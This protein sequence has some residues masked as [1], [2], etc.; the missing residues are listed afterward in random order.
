MIMVHKT[1]AANNIKAPSRGDFLVTPKSMTYF[2]LD[3]F[4]FDKLV[5]DSAGKEYE[6][7]PFNEFNNGSSH[8]IIFDSLEQ[9]ASVLNKWEMQSLQDW[10]EGACF[11]APSWVTMLA[12]LIDEGELPLGNYL[13]NISW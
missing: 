8:S 5:S 2:E 12:Y 11:M 10:L 1:H 3:Y 13:I 4:E 7:I 6:S 9:V